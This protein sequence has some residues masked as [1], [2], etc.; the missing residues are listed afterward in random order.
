LNGGRFRAEIS[1]RNYAGET[2]VAQTVP[3]GSDD[4]ALFW[5]FSADNWEMLV[6]VIDGCGLNDRFWVYSAASTDVEYTLTVT[7]TLTG[8]QKSYTNP[9]GQAAPANT[10]SSAFAT[11]D[12]NL[13]PPVELFSAPVAY[14]RIVQETLGQ[15]VE[16]EQEL[17]EAAGATGACIPSDLDG[18][19]EGGRFRVRINWRNY[20][21]QTGE[22][23]AVPFGSGN[24]ALFWFFQEDNWEMLVKV[25][26]GCTLNDRFWVFAA[27]TTDVEY[28]LS[29]TDTYTGVTK[30]Y[31]NPLGT[32]S[33]AL[34]DTSAFASCAAVGASHLELVSAPSV[35]LGSV[36]QTSNLEVRA[37]DA[38]GNVVPGAAVTWASSNPAL[39]SVSPTGALRARV[40]AQS[41][42]P[43]SAQVIA[44]WGTFEIAVDVL[45]A[46][47]RPGTVVLDGNLIL[48]R[49]ETHV[50]LQRNGTTEALQ[51]GQIL[52]SSGRWA[53]LDRI[54]S[55]STT[56]TTVE[57]G[58][59]PASYPQAFER[60]IV[61]SPGAPGTFVARI[62]PGGESYAYLRERS[63][64]LQHMTLLPMA[65][66]ALS[67]SCKYT[68]GIPAPV[69]LPGPDIEITAPLSLSSSYDSGTGEL[70]LAVEGRARVTIISSEIL[71]SAPPTQAVSCSLTLPSF[72]L[73]QGQIHV[74][75]LSLNLTPTVGVAIQ[76]NTTGLLRLTG[77]TA[78]ALG[79]VTGGLRYQPG[80][81][82]SPFSDRSFSGGIDAATF[83]ADTPAHTASIELSA[84]AETSIR[85]NLGVGSAGLNLAE[86][87]FLELK[88]Y[89]RAA[90]S[91]PQPL[92]P[93]SPTYLGPSWEATLGV[94]ADLG[95]EVTSGQLPRLF[96]VLG[97]SVALAG[98]YSL[99]DY[100]I[101]TAESPTFTIWSDQGAVATGES[102]ALSGAGSTTESG[103]LAFWSRKGSA[104]TLSPIADA[105]F[106]EGA[107]SVA[108]SPTGAHVGTHRIR[109][110]L[111]LDGISSIFPYA[112]QNEIEIEVTEGDDD[113]PIPQGIVGYWPFDG[114]AVDVSGN[115]HHGTNV[116]ATVVTGKQG[117]A[118]Q[119]S[120]SSDYIDLNTPVSMS[121]QFTTSLW[122]KPSSVSGTRRVISNFSDGGFDLHLYSGSGSVIFRVYRDGALTASA[123]GGPL[124]PVGAW[125]HLAGV[126]NGSSVLLYVNGQLRAS[127]PTGQTPETSSATIKVGAL[128]NLGLRQEDF[129]GAVDEVMLFNRPLSASEIATIYS[130]GSN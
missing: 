24:S 28:T 106:D 35:A 20:T 126:W 122:I 59:S 101:K 68:T 58:V 27:A 111:Y 29:V 57:L 91:L 14:G 34:N 32:R 115:G 38:Y 109:G 17:L 63:G 84:G 112:S 2:G 118:Y 67:L 125:T 52:T 36:G 73:L 127:A 110:R 43:G 104:T 8:T 6:K 15:T 46:Q 121:G 7:D 116:G 129:A 97:I 1:W 40:T 117:L 99:F 70:E 76:A 113:P 100:P 12:A 108:F 41:A 42:G 31:S 123:E 82:W 78:T 23:H 114:S 119:L 54:G 87:T 89:G 88:G 96:N 81:G 11:C 47:T 98:P 39:V 93:T 86:L 124:P 25:I 75:G 130:L 72:P 13:L 21:G 53:L 103:S 33:P 74:I 5:F 56:A 22:G 79:S 77:P 69:L 85:A 66:S 9:L 30:T 64:R 10:D 65:G 49:S 102:L 105:I 128:G 19:L 90:L 92:T 60:L 55:K 71:F 120:N 4:S 50:S 48:S 45:L 26:D 94:R 3:F 95:I 44:R 83:R 107:G 80:S 37:V 16:F 61:D 18:C 51:P 62:R